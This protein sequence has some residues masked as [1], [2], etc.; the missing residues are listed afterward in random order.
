MGQVLPSNKSNQS[1][2]AFVVFVFDILLHER[3]ESQKH[4]AFQDLL[5][6]KSE[7]SYNKS[8]LA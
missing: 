7:K 3:N 6:I 2:V 4:Q 8:F 1:Y 5:V